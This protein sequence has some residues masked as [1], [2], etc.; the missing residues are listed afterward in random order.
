M[1]ERL[2]LA[3]GGINCGSLKFFHHSFLKNR[4]WGCEKP[5]GGVGC[6]YREAA[7]GITGVVLSREMVEGLGFMTVVTH[8]RCGKSWKQR[9]NKTGHCAKCHESFEGISLFDKH[10]VLDDEGRVSCL[11]PASLE[12]PKGWPLKQDEYGTWSTTKPFGWK[13]GA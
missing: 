5:F 8:P 11:D 7:W 1:P 6:F 12:F 10:Q 13:K 3:A 4:P 2:F 9:G